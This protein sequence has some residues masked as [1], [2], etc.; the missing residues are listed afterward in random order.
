MSKDV[1]EK[2]GKPRN[3]HS[4]YYAPQKEA[5]VIWALRWM[6]GLKIGVAVVV[7]GGGLLFWLMNPALFF[8]TLVVVGLIVGVAGGLGLLWWVISNAIDA[9]GV[10]SEAR[11]WGVKESE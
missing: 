11:E 8:S 6:L 2:Y 1:I 9:F 3:T 7:A 5:N 4:P 10:L